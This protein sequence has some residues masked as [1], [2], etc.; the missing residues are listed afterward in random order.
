MHHC[1]LSDSL[2]NLLPG[3]KSS[4]TN[5]Q[6]RK[7]FSFTRAN[8]KFSYEPCLQLSS[9]TKH[10]HLKYLGMNQINVL[11]Y[12]LL[13]PNINMITNNSFYVQIF[14]NM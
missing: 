8:G 14:Q 11:T 7:V 5:V 12:S 3:N 1:E 10:T 6:F 2:E 13:P 9:A 4:F